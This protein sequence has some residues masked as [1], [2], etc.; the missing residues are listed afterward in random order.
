MQDLDLRIFP[1]FP[2]Y[3]LS[4]P[5]VCF[6]FRYFGGIC[7]TGS[8]AKHWSFQMW[9][10]EPEQLSGDHMNLVQFTTYILPPFSLLSRFL[11]ILHMGLSPS[12]CW[13][14]LALLSERQT[15]KAQARIGTRNPF[16]SPISPCPH[17]TIALC[18][19]DH[20]VNSIKVIGTPH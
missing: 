20:N 12:F 13:I 1:A 3:L 2:A 16:L 8:Q 11:Y 5:S 9:K 6:C 4:I 19:S 15:C 17:S 10:T 7:C 18:S 14:T